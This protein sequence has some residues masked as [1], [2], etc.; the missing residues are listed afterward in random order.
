M[1]TSWNHAHWLVLPLCAGHH[2]QG[3]DGDASKT[4]VHPYKWRFE[5]L[6]GSQFELYENMIKDLKLKHDFE[7]MG[8]KTVVKNGQFY[9]VK[10]ESI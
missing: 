6:Y 8:W 2:Q 9:E 10:N 5:R 1:S 4:A 7:A 3:A